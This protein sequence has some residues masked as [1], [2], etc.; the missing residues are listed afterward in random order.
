MKLV[1]SLCLLTASG[2][3]L[4]LSSCCCTSDTDAPSLGRMPRFKPMPAA[5]EMVDA[6]PE[7]RVIPAK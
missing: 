6:A 7:V 1:L 4:T 2:M 3:A 5:P